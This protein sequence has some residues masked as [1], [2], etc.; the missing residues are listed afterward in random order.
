MSKIGKNLTWDNIKSAIEQGWKGLP[1]EKGLC[2]V[3]STTL[4]DII[5]N[6]FNSLSTIDGCFTYTLYFFAKSSS[7]VT[8]CLSKS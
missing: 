1:K 4:L 5:S 2:L 7:D 6:S 3:K 8:L